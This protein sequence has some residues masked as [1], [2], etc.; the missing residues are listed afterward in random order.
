MH[1]QFGPG[2]NSEL[3][4]IKAELDSE[5]EGIYFTA[6]NNDILDFQFGNDDKQDLNKTRT[7]ILPTTSI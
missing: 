6:A 3:D 1:S 2:T 4:K 7:L 5:E